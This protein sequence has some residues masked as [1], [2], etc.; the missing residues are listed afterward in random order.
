MPSVTLKTLPAVLALLLLASPATVLSAPVNTI[1]RRQSNW[2]AS[3]ATHA[4]SNIDAGIPGGPSYGNNNF[5]SNEYSKSHGYPNSGNPSNSQSGHT[6]AGSNTNVGIP[7]G[8]YVNLGN[9]FD[10]TY[11]KSETYTPPPP[12]PATSNPPPPPPQQEEVPT[13]SQPLPPPPTSNP[14][15]VNE[16]TPIPVVPSPPASE[17]PAPPV[18]PQEPEEVGACTVP[19]LEYEPEPEPVIVP[20]PEYPAR[21]EAKPVQGCSCA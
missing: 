21:T 7:G 5:F 13:P 16:Y 12:P 18:V 8:P 10:N 17:I 20:E 9:Y 6:E 15:T 4:G 14:P 19:E 1:N 3:G 11:S 2:D